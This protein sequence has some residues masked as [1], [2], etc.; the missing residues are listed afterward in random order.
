MQHFHKVLIS[1]ANFCLKNI[2]SFQRYSFQFFFIWDNKIIVLTNFIIFL[3]IWGRIYLYNSPDYP[4]T[5][6]IE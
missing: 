4:E 6:S 3:V 1:L 5:R 2:V